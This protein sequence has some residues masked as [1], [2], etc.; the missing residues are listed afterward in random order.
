[1]ELSLLL[2]KSSIFAVE[3]QCRPNVQL[4]WAVQFFGG[5]AVAVPVNAPSL[6]LVLFLLEVQ[7]QWMGARAAA[8]CRIGLTMY[9]IHRCNGGAVQW[10]WHHLQSLSGIFWRYIVFCS[11]TLYIRFPCYID[12]FQKPLTVISSSGCE[13]VESPWQILWKSKK[14]P[15]WNV[16][17]LRRQVTCGFCCLQSNDSV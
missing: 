10:L 7:S 8:I 13:D 11:C 2:L 9:Y 5:G 12:I 16:F 15:D 3:T 1:M 6:V 17:R 14:G 4:T